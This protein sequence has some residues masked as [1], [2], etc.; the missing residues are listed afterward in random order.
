MEGIKKF[1]GF[2]L[3]LV[4]GFPF[5]S[6]F[7]GGVFSILSGNIPFGIFWFLLL[8]GYIT[9]YIHA[10]ITAPKHII[11][12]I[13]FAKDATPLPPSVLTYY[14]DINQTV[15][16]LR[17]EFVITP[18]QIAK[19][20]DKIYTALSKTINETSDN[21]QS[22]SIQINQI[23][24]SVSEIS[25]A[26]EEIVSK[27]LTHLSESANYNQR[28][29]EAGLKDLEDNLKVFHNV[30]QSFEN[31]IKSLENVKKTLVKLSEHSR[32]LEDIGKMITVLA[33]DVS[34]ET[35]KYKNLP[36]IT[37]LS[38]EI[39]TLSLSSKENIRKTLEILNIIGSTIEH[40][41][42][43]AQSIRGG[44]KGISDRAEGINENFLNIRDSVR[45]L[46]DKAETIIKTIEEASASL[47]EISVA[48]DEMNTAIQELYSDMNYF[49]KTFADLEKE[50]NKMLLMYSEQKG[51]PRVERFRLLSYAVL[52]SSYPLVLFLGALYF[53]N[54]RNIP[55]SVILGAGGFMDLSALI[56][57]RLSTTDFIVRSIRGKRALTNIISMYVPFDKVVEFAI[58]EFINKP[59]EIAEAVSLA[60]VSLR[61]KLGEISISLR[62]IIA[63][64]SQISTS[65]SEISGAFNEVL[66]P[67]LE[68]L[69]NSSKVSYTN[70]LN[71]YEYVSN[72]IA[73]FGKTLQSINSL[74]GS[75]KSIT[76]FAR[77]LNTI[78]TEMLKI[79][80][81][82]K[83]LSINATVETFK[84]REETSFEVISREIRTLSEKSSLIMKSLGEG[85]GSLRGN[86]GGIIKESLEWTE[87]LRKSSES[88]QKIK[89]AFEGI[90]F[91]IES[92]DKLIDEISQAIYE[93][94]S[95]INEIAAILSE[96]DKI[97]QRLSDNTL[98]IN[99]NLQTLSENLRGFI[100]SEKE[101]REGEISILRI[102]E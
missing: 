15:E 16:R 49:H 67:S 74:M 71:G 48:L 91:G 14:Y 99:D 45:I 60:L 62:Q 7:S 46:V 97:A 102:V 92:S 31:F 51:N 1:L 38:Q 80:Q 35:A 61:G 21:L 87:I 11:D 57:I 24:S 32:E 85:M 50:I 68:D 65:T 3:I 82:I 42:K 19:K 55:A 4:V 33:Y 18:F 70:A 10:R 25:R 86:I 101:E 58:E 66:L 6:L 41:I 28:N 20:I 26:F 5:I 79:I 59:R 9:I 84:F 29:V 43:E 75:L 89:G 64:I 96:L 63:Q 98:N 8:L 81:K 2:P 44:L 93:S 27:N 76:G 90:K 36:G 47:T 52:R 54:L 30:Y 12:V 95:S 88:A 56:L 83:I 73:D 69:K 72:N 94:S 37:K 13:R 53:W 34:L 39:R 17:N 77:D 100:P 22:I 78:L 40:N 23:S